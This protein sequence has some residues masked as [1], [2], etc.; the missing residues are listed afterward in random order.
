MIRK[1]VPLEAIF[2]CLVAIVSPFYLSAQTTIPL[3]EAGKVP[4]S[5]PVTT[6][7]DSIYT[8]SWLTGRDTVVIVP[9]TI[10]PTLTIFTPLAEKATG[11][12]VI[13]CSGGSYRNVA[14]RVE[15]I[16]AAKKLAAAGV[17]AFVLH[18]R[19]PR[20]DLMVN[21]EIGPI[22][23]AQRAMQ[24]VRE[25]AGE[26]GID[27]DKLGI[28]G[29]SA[30]GHLVS[31]AGTHFDKTYIDN[32]RGTNLRPDFMV[33]VYPVISFADSLTHL[34]SRRN[35]IGPDI[36]QEKI[37]EYS[38]ELQVT[39]ATPPTFIT[40]AVDDTVVKV[41]NS[42]CFAAA[43]Q[44]KHVPVKLFMYAKGGHGFGINNRTST[45]Q[46]IDPCIDWIR[47]QE[48]R[49]L[50]LPFVRR[51]RWIQPGFPEDSIRRPPPIFR[52]EFTVSKPVQS[53]IITI[54]AHGLYEVS[55]DSQRIGNAFF[56]PGFT[57]YYRRL[58]Y[59]HYEV[60]LQIHPG[61]NEI[62]VT[63]GDGWYRG[64]FGADMKNNRYGKDASLLFQLKIQ[65][66]DGSHETVVS[67]GSWQCA[68]GPIRY[69][70]IYNGETED[71]RIQ[72]L[73]WTFVKMED[74]FPDNLVASISE[75][76]RANE[77]FHPV[78]ILNS[79][80]G[81]TILDFGQN[82]A[83]WVRIT[84][85]G[86][87]GDTIR[88][89]HSEALDSAGNF[90]TGNLRIARAQDVYVLN[91]ESQ[92]LEPHFTYHGFRY[93]KVEGYPGLLKP[94]NFTAIA[95]YSDLKPT[96]SFSCSDR[97]L[98]Q[99]QHNICWS[100]KSNFFD[101]PTDCPQRSERFGWAGDAQMFARTASFNMDV[102]AFYLKWL[103]DLSAGQ[104][105]NGGLPVFI[106][107]FRFP[108]TV[109]PRGGVAGWGDAATILPWTLYEVYGDT[110]ILQ[111]QYSSMKAWV[112]Y[113]WH[114]ADTSGLNWKAK[115]YGD[116]YAPLGPTDIEYIDQCFFI[117]ST[118]LLIKAARVLG[119][120][121]DLERYKILLDKIKTLFLEK[122]WG[123]VG[124]VPNTQTAYV[125]ALQFDL[126]PD[127]LK[128]LAVQHL[129]ALI[130]ENKDHLATGFLG[131][132]YLLWVLTKSGNT[133][134]AFTLLR[135]TTPPSWLYPLNKGATTIW[136]KWDA[137]RPDGTFDTCSLNHYAYGAVGDWLYRVV[138]GIDAASPGYKKVIIHPHIG[139]GL[140]WVNAR[141]QCPYGEIVSSWK[142][143]GK[144]FHLEITI[145]PH[146]TAT[147]ILPQKGREES[148]EVG[149]GH[150]QWSTN[151]AE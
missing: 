1:T 33:L 14:D 112:N 129:V 116:W 47:K 146:T 75:P 114:T 27:G 90:Y 102:K 86:K 24:Y 132:P 148:R 138:A 128:H 107:D 88:L 37:I 117:H 7:V 16:P 15:G 103:A 79:A 62:R 11:I 26:Y 95:L 118:E 125:L 124:R 141:Y 38:N 59:Q 29:F 19:V 71:T 65:F 35:L 25:H 133:D 12:G 36:Y 49:E 97:L 53:A 91:G 55:L 92:T 61:E 101:I 30:G 43:L 121:E 83:G 48:W 20:S 63:V 99:L 40:H 143:S 56:T 51:A 82:L 23:D 106:P 94:E 39:S 17:T 113:I 149:S 134:L 69:S 85:T 130:H 18:Y 67:D 145:P 2:I 131:T 45:T 52:K 123:E 50:E 46:W 34:L 122:Y 126:L 54:T 13:V 119:K 10:M 150:Y 70:N 76:V 108:D 4:N 21:K 110:A 42:L 84:V 57:D 22:Q 96:G 41:A 64:E 98:N 31:T 68:T 137:I 80:K 144:V 135:Q 74:V 105:T 89:C 28:M 9:R 127:S 139:G 140:T 93:V 66:T 3:Y 8:Q 142:L 147:I 87:P 115:G 111:Q 78:K 77:Q 151:I 5:I 58:Q 120:T 32:P 73:D 60:S 44:Q 136:E 81:E 109:G 100:Q 104:G 6:L 72:P